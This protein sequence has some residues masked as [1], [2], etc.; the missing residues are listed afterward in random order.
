MV[1]V[2]PSSV[3]KSPQAAQYGVKN[4]LKSLVYWRVHCIFSATFSLS[5]TH[6]RLFQQAAS[7]ST[8]DATRLK[9]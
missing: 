9:R 4:G 2:S 3:L 6:L 7:E 1:S 8:C 5:C